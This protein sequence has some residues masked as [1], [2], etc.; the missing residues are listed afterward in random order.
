MGPPTTVTLRALLSEKS[1]SI[2]PLDY[3]QK[4]RVALVLFISMLHLF[5]TP[6][7]SGFVTL[8]D[9][10]FFHHDTT[11]LSNR[12]KVLVYQPF[13]I[14]LLP[15]A[16]MPQCRSTASLHTPRPVNLAVFSLGALLIQVI[17]DRVVDALDMTENMDM[18][19]ILSKYETGKRFSSEVVEN[20]GLH[21]E[22]VVKWCLDSILGVAGLWC[23]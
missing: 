23:D 6:W 15:P 5:G 20:G 8:D 10:F 22:T 12:D 1:A 11:Q 9:V 18:N 3:R 16:A 19:T 17:I 21:Y 4:L 14:K 7:L 2:P 13:V